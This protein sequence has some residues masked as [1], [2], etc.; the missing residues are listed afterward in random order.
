[1]FIAKGVAREHVG[2]KRE[3]IALQ[4]PAAYKAATVRRQ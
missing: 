1:M 2:R 4:R 3:A